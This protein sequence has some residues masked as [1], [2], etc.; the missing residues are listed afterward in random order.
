MSQT[1]FTFDLVSTTYNVQVTIDTENQ[2]IY[3]QNSYT[4]TRTKD[5]KEIIDII[6][7][8]D[9]YKTLCGTGYNRTKRSM[10]RE[11][12]AHNV[13]HENDFEINRTTSVDI[14][15]KESP[16]RK[17]LYAILSLFHRG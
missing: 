9:C 2:N 15:Q 7:S 16:L 3:I 11:W 8:K 6:M 10:I 1:S 12:K 13:L 4:V 14:D 5:M 17:I